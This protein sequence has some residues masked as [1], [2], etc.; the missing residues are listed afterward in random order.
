MNWSDRLRTQLASLAKRYAETRGIPHYFSLGPNPAVMFEPY[1]GDRHGNFLEA[2]Y[3]AILAHPS[4]RRR[5][6]KPHPRRRALPVEKRRQAKE[7]DSC[8]SSD[9]LLM[10]VFCF[11]EVARFPRVFRLFGQE[12]GCVPEFG[13]PGMVPRIGGEIDDTEIDMQLAGSF[14][15]AKLTE[16]DFTAKRKAHVELYRDFE[17]VFEATAL[18]Q[19]GDNYMNYQLIRNVLAAF[20]HKREFVLLCDSRRTDL[21]QSWSEVM[22]CIKVPELRSRCRV[23]LWQELA[24]EL[25]GELRAF[26]AEKYGIQ[27]T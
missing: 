10:N 13:V 17:A 14:V 23:V 7:L 18:P 26:L 21:L 20:A 9:A 15:E 11:P 22:R 25:P 1:D 6:C 2:S 16:A 4:W 8:N 24:A 5:E 19:D 27:A 12:S 3:R